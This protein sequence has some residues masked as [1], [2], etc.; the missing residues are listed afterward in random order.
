MRERVGS[1]MEVEMS[2]ATYAAPRREE[3]AKI[4]RLYSKPPETITVGGIVLSIFVGLFIG[5]LIGLPVGF[6]YAV[7]FYGDTA[8]GRCI[9]I[10]AILGAII[11]LGFYIY[12]KVH[13]NNYRQQ[14][15]REKE[16]LENE[17]TQ[18]TVLFE[19]KARERS[20]RFSQNPVT[21]RF[22]DQ[23]FNSYKQYINSLPRGTHIKKLHAK[24]KYTVC[25]NHISY[26]QN[27][28]GERKIDFCLERLRDLKSP[29]DQAALSQVIA[30][31]IQ[32]MISITDTSG[33][34]NQINTDYIYTPEGVTTIL[35]YTANNRHYRP[36]RDWV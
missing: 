14:R 4:E 32:S 18:Y 35:T 33:T 1:F 8:Y 34:F 16:E 27:E 20:V 10:C 3:I 22:S 25:S 17:I 9:L 24:Y 29:L 13:S 2:P 30:A 23:I 26:Q 6:V 31:N 12:D 11:I 19:E 21:L 28:Y 5:S 36:V 15:L 7:I